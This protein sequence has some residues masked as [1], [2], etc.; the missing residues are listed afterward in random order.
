[1]IKIKN[2]QKVPGRN[3]YEVHFNGWISNLPYLEF[4]GTFFFEPDNE[5]DPENDH[6]YIRAEIRK[7]LKQI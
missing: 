3:E 6:D 7:Q 2:I 5:F 1:M 4:L